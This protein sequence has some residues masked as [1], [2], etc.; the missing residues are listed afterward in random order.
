[1]NSDLRR[2]VHDRL[3]SEDLFSTNWSGLVLAA[4][5]GRDTLDCVLQ[6]IGGTGSA[7]VF[8]IH[9]GRVPYDGERC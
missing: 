3:V 1:M 7:T 6:N 2:L 5:D 9:V 8:V 4:C